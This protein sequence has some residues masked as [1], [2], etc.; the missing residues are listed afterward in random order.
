VRRISFDRSPLVLTS[1]CRSDDVFKTL[2]Q[3]APPGRRDYYTSI[4]KSIQRTRQAKGISRFW[5]FSLRDSR[6]VLMSFF[7]GV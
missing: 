6:S 3:T 4:R 1:C 5:L 7:D 2:V